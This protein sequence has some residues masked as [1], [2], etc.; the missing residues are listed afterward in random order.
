MKTMIRILRTMWGIWSYTVFGIFIL[1]YYLPSVGLYAVFEKKARPFIIWF[2]YQIIGKMTLL[3]ALIRVKIIGKEHI[4]KRNTPCV[5]ISNHTS[6]LDIFI[7]S[8]TYAPGI[9]FLAKAEAFKIPF[10][11]RILGFACVPVD[12]GNE[13]SR[14]ESFARMQEALS[15]GMNIFIYPEGTRNRTG[16]LLTPF[17]D[18]AF[19]LAIASQVPIVVST[20]LDAKKLSDPHRVID[21]CPGTVHIVYDAPISTVGM[22]TADV[23]ALKQRVREI[24]TSHLRVEV[25]KAKG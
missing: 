14:K 18:G 23:P 5:V 17:H 6:T 20:L 1:L 13:A 16:E 12:R 15:E 4:S 8:A 2:G 3:L 19:N 9:M 7:N 24:M 21:I 11:G 22:T 10:F 25:G